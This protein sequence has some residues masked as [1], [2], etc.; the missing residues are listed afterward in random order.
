MNNAR[1]KSSSRTSTQQQW[2]IIAVALI[3]IATFVAIYFNK[4]GAV[5]K[6]ISI[7][8]TPWAGGTL[9]LVAEGRLTITTL[10]ATELSVSLLTN[11]SVGEKTYSFTL[12]R[13]G[14]LTYTFTIT[15]DTFT[16][17][18]IIYTGSDDQTRIYLDDVDTTPDLE[19]SHHAGQITI[20]NMHFPLP[21]PITC[22]N[23]LVEGSEQC[24]GT[25]LN[26]QTCVTRG[27]A[28]GTLRCTATCT[29][30]TSSCVAAPSPPAAPVPLPFHHFYG[31][32][33]SLPAGTFTLRAKVNSVTLNS[34]S[35]D[36]EGYFDFS[37]NTTET[38]AP[39]RVAFYVVRN[40]QEVRVGTALYRNNSETELNFLYS[41]P[42]TTPSATTP[43]NETST[44]NRSTTNQ[45]VVAN[46][47]A[48]GNCTQSWE[49]GDWSLCR[50]GQQSRVCYRS[51]TCDQQLAQ[52]RIAAVLPTSKPSEQRACQEPSVPVAQYCAPNSKRCLGLELQQCSAD[53]TAWGT[54]TTCPNG[55][56]ALTLECK[57]EIAAPPV[58]QQPSS[59]WIYYL[60]GSAE[61]RIDGMSDQQIKTRLLSQG[62]EEATVDKLLKK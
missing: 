34:T 29:F 17:D 1:N 43:P 22:G 3:V 33:N 18:D 5:G 28:S 26:S 61:G 19:V 31:H 52:G 23:N 40:E 53:G 44:A 59:T 48:A 25:A 42:P 27:F 24:D 7:G 10:P 16:A 8:G 21:P 15:L 49:C 30:D 56:S 13:L 41:A 39:L 4:Q 60:L 50:N 36:A 54:L 2:V 57:S 6:A 45:T 47:T 38:V 20:R 46:R 32:V 55:C 14:D 9:N 11:S 37:I 12:R 51:D 58:Q 62:W 35:I